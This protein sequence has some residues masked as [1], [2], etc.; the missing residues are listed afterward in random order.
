MRI[1]PGRGQSLVGGIMALVV[2]V[3]GLVML[4][5]YRSNAQ[6]FGNVPGTGFLGVFMVVW[7]LFGLV[8]AGA[9]FYNAFSQRGLPTYEIDVDDEDPSTGFCPQCG[10][11]VTENDRFCR[12][13]GA[14]QE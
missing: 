8:G 5:S 10:R 1:R 2:M 13:C 6:G 4:G 3:M 12:H 9:A 14:R 11:P 7:V